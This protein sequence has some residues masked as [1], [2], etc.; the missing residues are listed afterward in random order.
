MK[1]KKITMLL[2]MIIFFQFA[3]MGFK[4]FV[5]TFLERTILTDT[6]LSIIYM[7]VI[8]SIILLII[9]KRKMVLDILP[10][11]FNKWY[12]IFSMLVFILFIS[13][14]LITQNYEIT[15]IISLIYNVVITVIYE[16]VIFRGIVYKKI[17]DN[18]KISYLWSTILFG[19]WHLGYVDTIIWRTTIISSDVNIIKIMFWKV[20]TGMI[21]GTILGFLRYK[22][23][24]V[25]SS[26][27]LHSTINVI[28]S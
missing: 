2:L 8:L 18:E 28:G 25:Y 16:E 13:T 14:P 5:F 15:N 19:L 7:I 17:S 21:I 24:N 27:L 22:N 4:A 11:K 20:I 6:I 9:N 23:K 3:R 10:K 1:L 12:V 26:M